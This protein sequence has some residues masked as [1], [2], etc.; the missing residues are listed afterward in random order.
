MV[1]LVNKFDVLLNEKLRRFIGIL[2]QSMINLVYFIFFFYM[3]VLL[4]DVFIIDI[5][6]SVY[7]LNII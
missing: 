7:D 1:F 3:F 2:G 5:M 4:C 6:F